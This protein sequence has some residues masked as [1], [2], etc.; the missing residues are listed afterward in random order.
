[1]S[2]IRRRL[3]PALGMYLIAVTA[4][5]HAS[6]A[7]LLILNEWNA[8]DAAKSLGDPDGDAHFASIMGNG[9]PW[10]ELVVVRGGDLRGCELQWRD[11]AGSGVLT[12]TQ[13]DL[14]AQ[15]PAG[16]L[17]TIIDKPTAA[18]GLDSDVS[19]DPKAGDWWI[20]LCA[21][22]GRY[23]RAAL[24]DGK[25][26]FAVSHDDWQLTIA[27]AAGLVT[28]GPVGEAAPGW[29]G[30]GINSQEVGR[31][32]M[33]PSDQVTPSQGYNDADSSTF[34]APNRW[35]DPAGDQREQDFS[36]LRK[37]PT[38]GSTPT[39]GS[40]ASP[41]AI[42]NQPS[43]IE[44][45]PAFTLRKLATI[46]VPAPTA[47]IVDYC[48]SERLLVATNP[49]WKTL[50]V[51]EL[52]NLDPQSTPTLKALDVDPQ[53]PGP[54]GFS[55]P[56]PNSVAVHPSLPL[57][58]VATPGYRNGD[59]GRVVAIDLRR[60]PTFGRIR[61]SQLVGIG[62]DSLAITPNGRWAVIACEAE[63][64]P[65]TDGSIWVLDLAGLTLTRTPADPPLPAYPIEGLEQ[66]LDELP[67]LIEPEYVAIDPQ[68][69]FAAVTLQENDAVALI[70]LR[71]PTPTLARV[72]QLPFQSQPDGCGVLDQVTLDG[73]V[74]CLLSAAEEGKFDVWRQTW[75]GQ[76]VSF[77]WLDPDHLQAPARPVSRVFVNDLLGS[78]RDRRREPESAYLFRHQGRALCLTAME[79]GD[80]LLLLD[81]TD[82]A[83]PTLLDRA[84]T[85]ERPEGVSIIRIG[86][87]VY[88]ITGDEGNE[89]PG[90]ISLFH[91][92]AG[93]PPRTAPK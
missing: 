71:T 62:P 90:Q 10:I 19:L 20:N 61:L 5:A 44:T 38:P 69:R 80:W 26:G 2:D 17:L 11:A 34:A 32:E 30:S 87:Q 45:I 39:P 48:A 46:D 74:G 59:P 56:A 24:A 53:R 14:W 29:P 84:R 93:N 23:L 7:P 58:L 75:T 1:M 36:T 50:D 91:L 55:L 35:R 8:V 4:P 82:P 89:G 77:L 60:G 86:N 49:L 63:D 16:V 42:S 22:D 9:G 72:L 54:Q 41:S 85:G 67:G 43:A 73:R 47:E 18:G 12:F 78:A 13:D 64:D 92:N 28:F 70:D 52:H 6:A 27:D 79:R 3:I 68:S 31:L 21:R 66:A 33:D 40:D 76:A 57:A 81:L 83:N 65:Y 15:V 37:S 88:P 51:F 25:P